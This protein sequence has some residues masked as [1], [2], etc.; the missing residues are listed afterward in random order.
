MRI[1][2]AGRNERRSDFIILLGFVEI[3]ETGWIFAVEIGKRVGDGEMGFGT[4]D[5]NEEESKLLIGGH[6]GVANGKKV[7][8]E[9]QEIVVTLPFPPSAFI[10]GNQEDIVVFEPF[11][12]VGGLDSDGIAGVLIRTGIH[13]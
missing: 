1:D 10:G 8:W 5:S 4:G 11:A 7:G 2:C 13:E 6:T 9:S 12:F 3:A